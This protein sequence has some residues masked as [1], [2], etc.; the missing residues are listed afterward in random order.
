MSACP[1]HLLGRWGDPGPCTPFALP[2]AAPL[3]PGTQT[4]LSMHA[5]EEDVSAPPQ[6]RGEEDHPGMTTPGPPPRP[7]SPGMRFLR[8]EPS[9]GGSAGSPA[10]HHAP[11]T[12]LL[13]EVWI[14]IPCFPHPAPGREA[15]WALV[16]SGFVSVFSCTDSRAAC[17]A[18]TGGVGREQACPQRLA[19]QPDPGPRC[20]L[21]PS[22]LL[23]T[24]ITPGCG[25]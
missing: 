3:T 1:R 11:D 19:H 24:A 16:L 6:G 4:S 22:E 17:P 12:D 18:S 10:L 5:E 7:T 23:V 20:L 14:W 15:A 2:Q 8:R 13:R 25:I 21:A 9:L